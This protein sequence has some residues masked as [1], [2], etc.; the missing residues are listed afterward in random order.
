MRII[1]ATLLLALAGCAVP[2]QHWYHQTKAGATVDQDRLECELRAKEA[3]AAV[4]NPFDQAFARQDIFA[5][6]M[7]VRGY[8]RG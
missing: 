7:R 6:C 2:Q 8:V 1:T 4:I 5:G 3:T